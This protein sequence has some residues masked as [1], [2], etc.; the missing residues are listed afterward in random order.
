MSNRRLALTLLSVGTLFSCATPPIQETDPRKLLAEACN[1]GAGIRS[2]RGGVAMK[3]TSKEASGQFPASVE[4]TAP[5]SVKLEITNLIGGTEA[6]ISVQNRTYKIEIPGK[7]ERTEKGTQTWGG[8]PLQWASDLFLG[9]IPCPGLGRIQELRLSRPGSGE[10]QVDVPSSLEGDA[11]VFVYKFRSV[12]GR[13]WP[14][15]LHWERK[16]MAVSK[17]DFR[18]DDPDPSTRSPLKWEARSPQ[19]EVKVRWKDRELR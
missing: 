13:P 2:V 17:V 7:P 4:A 8:I 1:P 12:A 15:S 19:G 11:Q 5:G 18:F 16:G 6:V 3:A 14:E 9:K 10:L